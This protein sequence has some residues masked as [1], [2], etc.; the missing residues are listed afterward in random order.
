MRA[1]QMAP[2]WGRMIEDMMRAGL[3]QGDIGKSMGVD[4]TDRMIGHYRAGVQPV[5]WRGEALV[6]LWCET[7]KKKR[8]AL[9]MLE[10]TR[11]H[12]VADN[13]AES[14]PRLRSLPQWPPLH[15]AAKVA[16]LRKK[17]KE[18]A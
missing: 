15:V 16:K 14:G 10:V 9:P 17:A 11:G 6:L 7:V 13:R 18:T 2:D 3:K 4:L 12:R 1:P 8:E 5:Y